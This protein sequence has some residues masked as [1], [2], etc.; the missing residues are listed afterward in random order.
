MW[1]N[2]MILIFIIIL[3]KIHKT[4]W[5]MILLNKLNLIILLTFNHLLIIM[6]RINRINKKVNKFQEIF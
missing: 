6:I 4:I 5:K 1:A 3:I 2:S